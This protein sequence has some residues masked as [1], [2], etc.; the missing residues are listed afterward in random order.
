M[1]IVGTKLN[2]FAL[3]KNSLFYAFLKRYIE[4]NTGKSARQGSLALFAGV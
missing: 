3:A 1:Y 4:S 2:I